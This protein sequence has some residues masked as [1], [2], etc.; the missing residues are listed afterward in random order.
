MW[1]LIVQKSYFTGAIAS[2]E[3]ILSPEEYQA[4]LKKDIESVNRKTSNFTT[5]SYAIYKNDIPLL[6]RVV[7]LIRTAATLSD[8]DPVEMLQSFTAYKETHLELAISLGRVHVLEELM[9]SVSF[10]VPYQDLAFHDEAFQK[11]T[12]P[13][14]GHYQGLSIHGA[15]N[16][17]WLDASFPVESGNYSDT[18][19]KPLHLAAYRA[20]LPSL[21]WIMSPRPWECL[22]HFIKDNKNSHHVR[23]VEE[24]ELGIAKLF[25]K[26]L[27]LE[28]S[29]LPHI[30]IAGWRGQSSKSMLDHLFSIAPETLESRTTAGL[31]PALYAIR[32][33]KLEAVEYLIQAGADFSARDVHARNVLHHLLTPK[34]MPTVQHVDKLKTYIAALPAAAVAEAWSQRCSGTLHTPIA[35]WISRS[36]EH[37]STHLPTLRLLIELSAGEGLAAADQLGNLPIHTLFLAGE[38]EAAGIV[39]QYHPEF[40]GVEN[41]N[42]RTLSEIA[43]AGW[44]KI[45]VGSVFSNVECPNLTYFRQ[46]WSEHRYGHDI[47]VKEWRVGHLKSLREKSGEVEEEKLDENKVRIKEMGKVGNIELWKIVREYEGR[48]RRKLVGLDVAGLLAKRV[49]GYTYQNKAGKYGGVVSKTDDEG[50]VLTLY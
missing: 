1:P 38:W 32:S 45:C 40:W 37:K 15:K 24:S 46:S 21:Q 13:T 31:T 34:E 26:G 18:Q 20:N 5:L 10:G 8:M 44:R 17:N 48:E 27:G 50:D 22:T 28:T 19:R 41:G 29:L 49:I 36:V 3:S 30:C 12:D 25:Q 43:E 2:P 11:A 39:L 42:G 33:L 16:K 7:K 14:S 35:A 23:M 6:K 47:N 9:S 4:L